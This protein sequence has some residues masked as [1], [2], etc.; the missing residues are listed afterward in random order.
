MACQKTTK[1]K[2]GKERFSPRSF[3]GDMDLPTPWHQ[4]S[5]FQSCVVVQLLSH[6]QFFAIHGL[7]HARLPCP[8]LTPRVCLNSSPLSQWCHPT[9]SSSLTRFSSGLQSFP[10]SGSFPMNRLFTSGGWSI[11]ASVSASVLPRTD[12]G[13]PTLNIHS[14]LISFRIDWFDLAVQGTF[15]SLLQHHNS[16]A[17]IIWCSV[18][19]MVHL[20]HPYMT[21]G[22]TIP[23]IIRTFISK[24]V[25]LLFN[26]LSRFVT[27]FLPRSKLLLISWLQSPSIVILE[28]KKIKSVIASTF[29]PSICHEKRVPK[30]SKER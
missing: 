8:S 11:G 18:F 9:I 7:Q 20:S 25:S 5:S 4:T 2:K 22:E 16:K 1:A 26:M 10:A 24:V 12:F 27:A 21:T 23:L 28:P 30:N 29:S 6:V 17:S 14:G 3:R 13:I 15:R 19:L